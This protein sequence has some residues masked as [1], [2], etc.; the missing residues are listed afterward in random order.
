MRRARIYYHLSPVEGL[1]WIDPRLPEG[2]SHSEARVSRVCVSSSIIGC[3]KGIQPI[4][5]EQLYV[6]SVA[7]DNN[8]AF[9]PNKYVRYMVP[10][11]HETGEAW[12][13]ESTTA[14]CEGRIVV[15]E[16]KGSY[17]WKWIDKRR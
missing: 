10:D 17:S 3:I 1:K 13:M 4:F 5:G 8:T 11:A 6:Y 15:S 16:S 12:V 2:V 9:I 7:I 14:C